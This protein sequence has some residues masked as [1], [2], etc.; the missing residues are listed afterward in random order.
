MFWY[1][2][3]YQLIQWITN[4]N[5]YF[6]IN[7]GVT[8][9]DFWEQKDCGEEKRIVLRYA[10]NSGK[11]ILCKTVFKRAIFGDKN[12]CVWSGERSRLII[13]SIINKQKW[14]SL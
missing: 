3:W 11:Q 2:Y 12:W 7:L 5:N 6:K 14:Y 4:I 9:D 13:F 10:H 8:K 1:C